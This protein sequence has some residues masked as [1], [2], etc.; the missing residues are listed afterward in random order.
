[1]TTAGQGPGEP[2]P[3]TGEPTPGTPAPATGGTPA[4]A[5]FTQEDVDRI[6]AAARRD[7]ASSEAKKFEGYEDYKEKADKF[8]Q[9]QESQSTE[10]EKAQKTAAT[11]QAERARLEGTVAE[12][13]IDAEV[14]LAAQSAGMANPA[15][16]LAL[17]TRGSITYDKENRTVTGAKE[18]VEAMLA[19]RPYLKG[20]A[21]PAAPNMNGGPG[22]P[23]DSPV[24]LSEA[25]MV[26]AKKMGISNED[27][28][29]GIQAR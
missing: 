5:T 2:A 29:K 8:D 27:Y 19:E 25:Q 16:A 4:P 24:A 28:A 10:L 6:A 23:G 18:A 17:V 11:E 13:M 26:A 21:A 20:T 15:D 3:T 9:Y 12:T 22:K 14:K 1:M 7:G